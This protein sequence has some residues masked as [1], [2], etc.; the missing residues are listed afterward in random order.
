MDGRE[1]FLPPGSPAGLRDWRRGFKKGLEGD[2]GVQ[3]REGFLALRSP[4]EF[5]GEALI[6]HRRLGGAAGE[7]IDDDP[8][9]SKHFCKGKL[10]EDGTDFGEVHCDVVIRSLSSPSPS[11]V[12]MQSFLFSSLKGSSSS[13]LGLEFDISSFLCTGELSNCS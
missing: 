5:W 4:A 1:G 10:L 9:N 13:C 12:T 2:G 3:G 6:F 8:W 7:L 11:F